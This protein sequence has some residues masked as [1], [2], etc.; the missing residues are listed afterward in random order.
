MSNVCSATLIPKILGGFVLGCCLGFVPSV[1]QLAT[2]NSATLQWA[3]N[4][5]PDLAGYKVYQGT[6]AGSYGPSIDVK[7]V[8]TYTAANLQGGLTYSFAITAYDLSGNESYPSDEVSKYIADSSPDLTPPDLSLPSQTNET[9]LFGLVTNHEIT[10]LAQDLK[11]TT[12]PAGPSTF[13]T[14]VP[15]AEQPFTATGHAIIV[16]PT[17]II[18]SHGLKDD[19]ARTVTERNAQVLGGRHSVR[20]T[21]P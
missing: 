8:T 7:N 20:R 6:T 1:V 10:N 12:P 19:P 5:E 3:A 16:Q 21:I 2:A 4:S 14:T 15:L 17:E 11:Q 13:S 9:T 18:I